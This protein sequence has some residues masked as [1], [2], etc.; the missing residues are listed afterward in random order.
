VD[1]LDRLDVALEHGEERQ[2]AALGHGPLARNERDVGRRLRQSFAGRLAQVRE[3]PDLPD[4]VRCDHRRLTLLGSPSRSP[5]LLMWRTYDIVP[6]PPITHPRRRWM[7]HL[8]AM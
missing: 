8:R 5:G 7:D 4:L 3:D 1:E 2:F 6:P